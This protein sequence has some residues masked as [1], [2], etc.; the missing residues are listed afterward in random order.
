M[1]K[2]QLN[3]FS[4]P[5]LIYNNLIHQEKIE[6]IKKVCFDN[7]CENN[8]FSQFKP[9]ID[10]VD[11]HYNINDYQGN[12][13]STYKNYFNLL[14]KINPNLKFD[15]LDILT[16]LVDEYSLE[17]FNKKCFF[18]SSWFNSYKD[19]SFLNFHIHPGADISGILYLEA[20]KDSSPLC[21]ENHSLVHSYFSPQKNYFFV[22]AESGMLLLFPSWLKHGFTSSN[23][24]NKRSCL[25]FNCKFKN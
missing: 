16:N 4:V 6:H 21:F 3:L 9:S 5:L 18:Q 20:T 7:I 14:E 13:S 8:I 11:N 1:N 17:F 2:V 19:D 10:K 15:L 12:F 24:D 25:A 23:K 22:N